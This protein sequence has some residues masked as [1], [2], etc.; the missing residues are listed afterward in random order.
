[1]D[2]EDNPSLI[3]WE[4]PQWWNQRNHCSVW[5]GLLFGM[6]RQ[7]LMLRCPS[8]FHWKWE[9]SCGEGRQVQR[10]PGS[11]PLG[12]W[13]FCFPSPWLID[14]ETYRWEVCG[15]LT[16]LL[17]N[18]NRFSMSEEKL[19]QIGDRDTVFSGLSPY[20]SLNICWNLER[21]QACHLFWDIDCKVNN[22]CQRIKSLWL[23]YGQSQSLWWSDDKWNLD[24]SPYQAQWVLQIDFHFL[25]TFCMYS[26][27]RHS[28]QL[29]ITPKYF[30]LY[31]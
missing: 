2:T 31:K 9:R 12:V 25:S 29:A 23:F 3:L 5:L 1:M 16:G 21:K 14:L 28:G 20:W 7:I 10:W 30:L 15:K 19:T 18:S 13:Y 27:E 22:F 8:S 17:K 24:P 11:H 26:R 4:M 6:F